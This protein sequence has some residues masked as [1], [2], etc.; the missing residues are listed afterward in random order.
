MC[1]VLCILF[2]GGV[3]KPSP[4]NCTKL[5]TPLKLLC[6]ICNEGKINTFSQEITLTHTYP[7][8]TDYYS[9]SFFSS[10]QERNLSN[11]ELHTKPK[12]PETYT[13]PLSQW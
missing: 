11:W 4:P 10:I 9:Y 2:N 1:Q 8:L 6:T 12:P 7:T 13:L 5:S 3:V